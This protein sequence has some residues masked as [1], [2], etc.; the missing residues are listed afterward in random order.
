MP[1]FDCRLV[2][3]LESSLNYGEIPGAT[4]RQLVWQSPMNKWL[5]KTITRYWASS[6]MLS[7]KR[8]K[9]LS[10]AGAQVSPRRQSGDKSAEER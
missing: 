7:L 5:R 8:S 1:I 3:G 6:V 2:V 10:P 4:N 9:G